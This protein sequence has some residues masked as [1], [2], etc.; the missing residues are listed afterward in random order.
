MRGRYEIR[1]TTDYADSVAC[2]HQV[3]ITDLVTGEVSQARA[4]SYDEAE[5]EAWYKLKELQ[6]LAT[7]RAHHGDVQ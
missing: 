6:Q 7:S 2:W 4:H 3:T 5:R 1:E